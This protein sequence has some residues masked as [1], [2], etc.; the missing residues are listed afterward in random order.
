[1]SRPPAAI[2]IFVKTPRLSPVKTR[3]ARRIG[4]PL[5]EEF[6]V[7]AAAAVGAAIKAAS[8]DVAIFPYWAVAE[9]AGLANVLWSSFERVWQGNGDLGDRLS[10]IFH[11]L[12]PRH[13]SVL[14]LGADSPAITPGILKRAL[15]SLDS[16]CG[17]RYVL[18][19]AYDGGFYLAGANTDI[20]R[21]VWQRV[22]YGS[23]HAADDM[24]AQLQE[25]APVVEVP[26]L[27]DVDTFEDLHLL[28]D[29]LQTLDPPMAE[30]LDLLIWCKRVVHEIARAESAGGTLGEPAVDALGI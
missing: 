28:I 12:L 9:Q 13:Q 29:E 11:Q 5:A 18:G 24:L 6:H 17:T 1:M 25:V 27:L 30:Q 15:A 3:L 2:A 23:Q 20:P 26:A 22:R 21:L 7:R 8:R 16:S 10:H 4:L 14:F 19:K